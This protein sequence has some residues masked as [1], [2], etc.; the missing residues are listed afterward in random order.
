[1]CVRR[2]LYRAVD[3][4]IESLNAHCTA[5]TLGPKSFQSSSLFCFSQ[6]P[7]RWLIRSVNRRNCTLTVCVCVQSEFNCLD[8]S[9]LWR[10]LFLLYWDCSSW[11]ILFSLKCLNISRLSLVLSQKTLNFNFDILLSFSG[12]AHPNPLHE[13]LPLKNHSPWTGLPPSTPRSFFFFFFSIN[14]QQKET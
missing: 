8:F 1:M 2:G 11:L 7:P 9:V 4:I 3:Q 14:K 10:L 12:Y 13:R 5:Q 6:I